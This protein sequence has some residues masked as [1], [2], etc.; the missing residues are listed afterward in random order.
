M[1]G[2]YYLVNPIDLP[3]TAVRPHSRPRKRKW[4]P[5]VLVPAAAACSKLPSPLTCVKRTEQQSSREATPHHRLARQTRRKKYWFFLLNPVRSHP[6]GS[7]STGSP[8][9]THTAFTA[10]CCRSP[11]RPC[12]ASLH[13]ACASPVA[14]ATLRHTSVKSKLNSSV[15]TCPSH[16]INCTAFV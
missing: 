7:I 3:E 11:T 14:S 5:R 13:L 1:R 2:N 4:S 10:R 15:Q 8:S 12:T 16:L 6:P 9:H